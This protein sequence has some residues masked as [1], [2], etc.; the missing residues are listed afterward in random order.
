MNIYIAISTGLIKVFLFLGFVFFATRK[1]LL[2]KRDFN[3]IFDAII[4]KYVEY[5]SLLIVLLFITINCKIY[6]GISIA[7]IMSLIGFMDYLQISNPLK[8]PKIVVKKF[9]KRLLVLIYE[10]EHKKFSWLRI[11]KNTHIKLGRKNLFIYNSILLLFITIIAL[12]FYFIK[13]DHYLFSSGWFYTLEMVNT[14]DKNLWFTNEVYPE[15]VYAFINYLSHI[16]NSSPEISIYVYA[17]LQLLLVI[18]SIFWY[19]QKMTDSKVIIPTFVSIFYIIGF[20][21][22][23]SDIANFYQNSSMQLALTL[24]LPLC[25]FLIKPNF[26]PY[27]RNERIAKLSLAFFA[28]ALIDLY[29]FFFLLPLALILVSLFKWRSKK[30]ENALAYIITFVVVL[31]TY[32]YF[33]KEQSETIFDLFRRVL[34]AVDIYFHNPFILV[35]V[36]KLIFYY[37]FVFIISF[38]FNL[39][40]AIFQKKRWRR[41]MFTFVLVSI[42]YFL[43]QINCKWLDTDILFRLLSVFIPIQLGI[44]TSIIF[45]ILK[46][47]FREREASNRGGVVLVLSIVVFAILQ[48]SVLAT[49]RENKQFLFED[50]L[51]ANEMILQKYLDRTYLVVNKQEYLNLSSGRRYFLSYDEFLNEK[52]L[53]KDQRYAKYVNN[54]KYLSKHP[55][56][57]LP[58]SVFVFLYNSG[59]IGENKNDLLLNRI[60]YLG[61]I[62]RKTRKVF[63]TQQLTVYEII[64]KQ[65]ASKISELVF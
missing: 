37:Q 29:F 65:N 50:V 15:G 33:L 38:L 1:F 36:D 55:D 48:E 61:S 5:Q 54:N 51:S 49:K 31:F 2:L 27:Q 7:V 39:F 19:M 17:I 6:D 10:L 44:T 47:Y 57:V 62:G 13:F 45:D 56:I 25:V 41:R 3:K 21:Y 18:M 14:K 9:K 23:P 11:I 52:Y 4:R 60:Q 63:S 32:D 46:L 35:N 42:L 28:I 40:F 59:E 24:F 22:L 12:S 64:N 30:R 16:T 26:L 20:T 43:T 34:I 8:I 53:D 58:S